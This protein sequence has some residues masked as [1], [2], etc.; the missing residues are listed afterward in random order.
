MANILPSYPAWEDLAW[1][2]S[3][4]QNDSPAG[5]G[6]GVQTLEEVVRKHVDHGTEG[7][8][9][10]HCTFPRDVGTVH[11]IVDCSH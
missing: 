11:C 10:V 9:A 8:L 5:S 2:I 4:Y 7:I 3:Q 6:R 1:V